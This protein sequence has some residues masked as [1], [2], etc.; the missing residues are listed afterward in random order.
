VV[1]Q[2]GATVPVAAAPAVRCI[3]RTISRKLR[4]EFPC[5]S[6]PRQKDSSNEYRLA[7]KQLADP[8]AP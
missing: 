4:P 3:P 5:D 1:C 8:G 2:A 7:S 6:R